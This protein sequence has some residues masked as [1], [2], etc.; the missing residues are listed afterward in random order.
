MPIVY[1]TFRKNNHLLIANI[2]LFH[3]ANKYN[4]FSKSCNNLQKQRSELC[5]IKRMSYGN[6]R[7]FIGVALSGVESEH[8]ALIVDNELAKIPGIISHKVELNNHKA[9]ITAKEPDVLPQAVETIR[10][11]GYDVDTV[12]KTFPVTGMS[13]ASCASSAET[14][15]TSQPG[16]IKAGVNFANASLLV[17]YV[18][19]ITSPEKLKQA[20][21]DVGYDLVIENSVEAKQAL[22]DLHAQKLKALK[23]RTLWSV[24]LSLPLVTIGMFL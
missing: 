9:I 3:K 12:K 6:D 21:Q 10:D 16:V 11:L 23:R 22:E 8:C 2:V 20:V 7:K 1:K 13:C 5:R 17:E 4:S 18:P 19:T 24:A 14:I 15:V